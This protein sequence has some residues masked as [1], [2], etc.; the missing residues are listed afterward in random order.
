MDPFQQSL[1]DLTH[2]AQLS[3]TNAQILQN[4]LLGNGERGNGE[5]ARALGIYPE[6][7]T[8][9]TQQ[10]A[11][12]LPLVYPELEAL[13]QQ[14]L[15]LPG[16]CLP[17]LWQVWLPLALKLVRARQQWQQPLLQGIVGS[18]GAGK[19]TLT[20]I[21]K[22]IL[23]HLGYPT[24]SLS[25]DDFYLTYAERQQLQQQDPRLIWRGPPGTHDLELAM[26]VLEQ[27]RCQPATPVMVP[28]FD[29]TAHGGAG[30]RLEPEPVS[31]IE[32]VL[33][34][35]WCVGAR[36]IEP[37]QFATAP[38]PIDT[39]SDRD[40]ARDMNQ[41]LQA[42]QPLWQRL[43][44]LIVLDLQEYRF[45]YQWRLQAEQQAIGQGKTGMSQLD[46]EQFVDYF[47]RALHPDLFIKPLTR[48]PGN[49]VIEIQPDHLPG[50]VYWAS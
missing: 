21:L 44:H 29:K 1:L 13:W 4:L 23:T 19:T 26:E 10:Q 20:R 33:F 2:G 17:V 47:W 24:L 38:P 39:D 27:L 50:R 3:P 5:R 22:I 30:E 35:G 7:V 18:Q 15:S 9:I 37:Q 8:E 32:I 31:G 42:Y 28:R 6:T 45:S 49:L 46:V 48:I 12:L 43:D 34:E 14:Q 40:F 11:Q 16:S 25:L 36:P 41:A